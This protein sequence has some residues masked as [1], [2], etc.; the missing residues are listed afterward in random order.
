MLL[1]MY[2]FNQCFIRFFNAIIATIRSNAMIVLM[3]CIALNV[4]RGNMFITVFQNWAKGILLV[5]W[6][7]YISLHCNW[8][9]L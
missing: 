7:G 9:N 1:L 2:V 8:S 3:H 4:K 6:L 5:G